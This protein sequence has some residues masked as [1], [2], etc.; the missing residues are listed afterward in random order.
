MVHIK[1]ITASVF[2]AILL[3][4]SSC[5]SNDLYRGTV[6]LPETG[7]YKDEAAKFEVNVND[8]ITGYDF[9]LY[10]RNTTGYR[11]SNL[12]L[13]LNTVF[14]NG[15]KTED[16]IELVLADNTGRWLGK[17]GGSTRENEIILKKNLRFPLKGNYGFYV[18]Q[19]MRTDTLKGIVNVGLRLSR[20][21]REND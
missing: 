14:P 17:G 3:L 2:A 18:R 19:A 20:S 12:F 15:N 5:G 13:F 10:I 4:L 6:E 9:Y 1:V 21:D 11:Y 7:W 16:T 8:T